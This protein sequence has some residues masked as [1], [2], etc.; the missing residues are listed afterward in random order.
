M[1]SVK[2]VPLLFATLVPVLAR[3]AETSGSPKNHLA[4][5]A[6]P[7]PEPAQHAKTENPEVERYVWDLSSLYTD[8]RDLIRQ[9]DGFRLTCHPL[10]YE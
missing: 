5:S 7:L 10:T 8:W 3:A 2:F 1:K 4:S 9:T 6:S